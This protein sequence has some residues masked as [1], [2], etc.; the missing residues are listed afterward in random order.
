MIKN[1]FKIGIRNL[2]SNK[3]TSFVNIIGL[4][5]GL[6]AVIMIALYIRYEMSY[7]KFH[8]DID[9]LY[10]VS[11][12][13]LSDGKQEYDSS[14][15]TSGIGPA[16]KQ[17]MADVDDY[18]RISINHSAYIYYNDKTLRVNKIRYADSTFFNLF[19][20][21]M[22]TGNPDR[23]LRKPKSILI[24][25]KMAASI[26]GDVNS[27]GKSIR[28]DDRSDYM[29]EGIIKAPPENSDID[30]NILV[31]FESLYHDDRVYMGWQ[32][33]N[34]Y[35]T[36]VKLA[37]DTNPNNID[38]QFPEFMWKYINKDMAVVGAKVEPYLQ[39]V[40]DIHL[41]YNEKNEN[42][43]TNIYIFTF[44]AFLILLIACINY[45][46][47]NT[48]H[49]GKRGKE[50]GVRKLLGANK[51]G[52][53]KQFL[54]ESILTVTIASVFS[55]LLVE[56]ATPLVNNILGRELIHNS[57]YNLDFVLILAGIVLLVGIIGG[58]YPAFYLS[59]FG[60][61]KTIKGV[62]ISGKSKSTARNIMVVLQFVISVSLITCTFLISDQLDFIK[63]KD[64]GF[65]KE[66]VVVIPLNNSDI[67]SKS[68]IIKERMRTIPSVV[69]VSA[70]SDV[71][72]NGFTSNGYIHE[73]Q[74]IAQMIHV[75]DADEEFLSTYKIEL[76]TGENFKKE[77]SSDDDGYLINEACAK[78]IGWANPIGKII[79]RNG[80]HKVIGVI[81]DFN[82]A[83]LHNNIEPLIITNKPWRNLHS[84]VS[85]RLNSASLPATLEEIEEAWNEINPSTPFEYFFLDDA[86]NEV[87]KSEYEFHNLFSAFS[88]LG[89]FIALL[90]LFSLVSF[91]T[92]NRT[93]EIG[94]RKVLGAN[95]QCIVGLLT[96]EFLS[97]VAIS[98][99]IAWPLAYYFIHKWLHEFAF[100]V[101]IDIWAF[102][103][104]GLL[105]ML[106]AVVTISVKAIRAAAA[107]PVKLLRY[108]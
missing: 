6:A 26:F 18:T 97:L 27:I 89:I 64:L 61:V 35:I 40:K 34:Q 101:D 57:Y 69:D 78:S 73:G 84:R 20:Y 50:I 11:I 51:T 33:G 67:M 94:I 83:S 88:T 108:E 106:V 41:Y 70:S 59:S 56:I 95:T 14:V 91:N 39:P 99:I 107:N 1:Y 58:S 23:V 72:Y 81:K 42:I 17:D 96:V 47:L 105:T 92:E 43:L 82:Y 87:Y 16:M 15:F 25:D 48:A 49:A 66:N 93:K 74:S 54:A 9:R 24:T 76:L 102:L 86:F 10:R 77:I 13:H 37:P 65:D 55:V 45:I 104:S 79:E 52:L 12:V 32:G 62:F 53:I 21:E 38:A 68:E 85:I 29:I 80:P 100:R 98:N 8:R 71:P 30:F 28:I 63:N 60:I 2:L 22:V 3:F 36:Y 7:D 103:L 46:N 90:G 75:V 4:S 19:S 44:I 31:S 5:V